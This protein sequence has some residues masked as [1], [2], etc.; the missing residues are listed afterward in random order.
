MTRPDTT[1]EPEPLLDGQISLGK[2]DDDIYRPLESFPT[3]RWWLAISVT[4]T[5][6]GVFAFCLYITVSRGIGMWGNNQPVGWAFGITNF[7]FWIGIGHA[8]TLISAIL[9]LFR[10]KWRTSINRSAEA[11]TIFAVMCAGL[12]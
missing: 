3:L 7:V 5:L 1:L 2:L 6:A 10:Q 9:L 12:L 8:G 4:G 11:M